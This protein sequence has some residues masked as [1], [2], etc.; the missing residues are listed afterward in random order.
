MGW[1]RLPSV[2]AVAGLLA[3]LWADSS[4]AAPKKDPAG[5]AVYM[6]QLRLLFDT[7]DLNSDGYLDKHELAKAFRGPDAKPYEKPAGGT[8]ENAKPD[9]SK[10]PDHVLLVELDV[11]GD[12]KISKVEFENW[13]RDF[14]VSLKHREQALKRV[15]T[16]EHK[17]AS[18][19]KNSSKLRPMNW[20][21][22]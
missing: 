18:V 16:A 7:W 13:A 19:T 5:T 2:V 15:T 12:G 10:Y 14:A 8:A 22:A 6:G 9:L 17:V 11:N 3:L 1:T 21:P 20:R 4:R